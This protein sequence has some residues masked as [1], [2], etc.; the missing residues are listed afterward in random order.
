ML[1]VS[2][3]GYGLRTPLSTFFE[4][5]KQ[6]EKQ[7]AGA[8]VELL[9]HTHVRDDAIELFGFLSQDEKTLFEK[10]ISVSGIGP[11]L[12]LNI[13]SGAGP[14]DLLRALATSDITA[15]VG[16]PGIGKK[17]AERM[18]LELRDQ[19]D[20]LRGELADEPSRKS[21]PAA[22]AEVE[23]VQALLGLGYKKA[24]AEREARD[25]CE[26]HT[27]AEFSEQL[28]IALRRLSRF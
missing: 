24:E 19:A 27:E 9:V 11:R 2:G 26:E 13:L 23:L 5:E 17:T 18:V 10:L 6:L 20:Q 3:V 12:A 21:A 28:R 7:G 4:L 14:S 15:L 25:V 8:T 16:I 1:D 22:T